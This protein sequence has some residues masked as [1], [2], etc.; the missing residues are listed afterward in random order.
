MIFIFEFSTWVHS[1]TFLIVVETGNGKVCI[2]D[3]KKIGNF[4]FSVSNN[5]NRSGFINFLLQLGWGCC[6]IDV[7]AG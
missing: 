5:I 7:K 4:K 1:W 3:I 6:G 2:E